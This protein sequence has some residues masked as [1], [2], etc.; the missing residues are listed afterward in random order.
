MLVRERIRK[1]KGRIRKAGCDYLAYALMDALVDNYFVVLE[2]F[3]EK[4]EALEEDLVGNPTPDILESIHNM[5]REMIFLRKRIWPLREVVS[6]LARG[7]SS[8]VRESTTYIC[9]MCMIIPF[10]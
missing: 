6:S 2:H 1:G 3:G 4:M 7:E 5:K 8:L 10:R 9:G